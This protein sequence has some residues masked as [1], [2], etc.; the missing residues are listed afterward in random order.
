[1]LKLSRDKDKRILSKSTFCAIAAVISG[2]LMIFLFHVSCLYKYAFAEVLYSVFFYATF[3]LNFYFIILVLHKRE[4]LELLGIVKLII[5]PIIALLLIHVHFRQIDYYRSCK[6]INERGLNAIKMLGDSIIKFAKSNNGRLPPS[7]KWSDLL[8]CNKN[9]ISKHDFS[10]TGL[11]DSSFALNSN[12]ANLNLNNLPYNIVLLFEADENFNLSGSEELLSQKRDKDKY[13]LREK[14]IFIYI[15]FA[16]STIG[17]YRITD[18]AIS[19]YDPKNNKFLPYTVDSPYA[20]PIWIP[21][22]KKETALR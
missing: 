8:I 14:D 12:V 21:E 13:F 2:F 9:V 3:I 20:N 4:C 11:S 7:D 22:V 16:D 6:A 18:S 19:L 5:I 17:R 15:Y 10:F 1:M